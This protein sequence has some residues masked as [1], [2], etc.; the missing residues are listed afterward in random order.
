MDCRPP[1]SSVHKD[2]P[3]KNSGVGCHA[4]FQ[5][6]F[7][8]Q[9]LKLSLMS[10]ALADRF[11]TTNA[12]WQDCQIS[13]IY[14]NWHLFYSSPQFVW[15]YNSEVHNLLE[16]GTGFVEDD[17]STDCGEG[18]GCL[19]MI[20]MNYIYCVLYFCYYSIRSISGLRN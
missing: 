16:P 12:T 20:Q 7:P 10:P 11:F 17:F 4:L 18:V 14:S 9:G 1:G 3:D 2:S 6:T 13:L 19:G 8:T 5:E 15:F